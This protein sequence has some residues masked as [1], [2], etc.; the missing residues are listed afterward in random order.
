MTFEQLEQFIAVTEQDSFFDAA[1][2]LHISQSSLSKQIKKLEQELHTPLL[3]R[4]RRKASLTPAG[5]TF[6]RE[7]L[8]LYRQYLRMISKME[9]FSHAGRVS[10]RVGTLPVLTQY[11]LTAAFKEFS[12]T[13][14]QFHLILE[15]AE[16]RELLHGLETGKY[17]LILAREALLT[18]KDYAC[19]KIAADELAAVL[20]KD[21]PLAARY[22]HTGRPAALAE[23]APEPF[24][25]MHPYTSVYRLCME[26]FAQNHQNA[27]IIRTAR[28]ESIISAVAVCEGISLLP[29]CSFEVFHHPDITAVPL[30]IAV[31]LTVVLAGKAD[32]SSAASDALIAFMQ[33][34]AV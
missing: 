4:T 2:T 24:L 32:S 29:K 26:L 20:P 19:Y 7:A 15:E 3:D 10:L 16:E 13:H 18:G 22:L 27:R 14:P 8:V 23:L 12:E 5:E 34:A 17:D 11:H 30:D 25:F 1:E 6:Y 28:V 21:H 31:P 9:T 33:E